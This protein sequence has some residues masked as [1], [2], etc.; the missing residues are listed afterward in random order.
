MRLTSSTGDFIELDV[1]GYEF[2]SMP[3]EEPDDWDANWL[4]VAGR[5]SSSGRVWEFREP[6]LTTWE[7]DDL[8]KFLHRAP[9]AGHESI[10]FTEPNLSVE[11]VTNS[12]G[13]VTATFTFRAEAAP[14]RTPH[15]KRWAE[16]T[17]VELSVSNDALLTAADQW[18]TQ[19]KAFPAR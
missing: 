17:P 6:C 2:E 8:L 19:L 4:L 10:E 11:V 15:R 1:V 16:G 5:V 13:A 9:A 3:P 7:A 14:P 12:P 18:E